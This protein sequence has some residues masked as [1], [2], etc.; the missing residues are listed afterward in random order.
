MSEKGVVVKLF[1]VVEKK[2]VFLVSRI[3]CDM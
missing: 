1:D 2:V 3:V